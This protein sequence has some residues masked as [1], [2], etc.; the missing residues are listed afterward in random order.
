MAESANRL[1]AEVPESDARLVVLRGAGERAFMSG[2]DIGEQEDEAR[3]ERFLRE[4]GAMIAAIGA[5]PLPV[6]AV[7][8]GYCLGA[9]VAVAAQSDLRIASEDA[10]FGV[11]AARL[12]L[13]YPYP[14]VARLT[15]LVGAGA[16]ADLLLTGRRAGAEEALR[17]GLVQ[18]LHAPT[19]LDRAAAATAAAIAANAPLSLRTAKLAVRTAAA[20]DHDGAARS[21]VDRLYAECGSSRDYA[22][23]RA[24]FRERRPPRFEGR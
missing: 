6:L 16:A 13:A 1:L 23:G 8:R 4:A 14:E 11:P 7:V 10:E 21:E 2:A 18:S 9:G 17:W 19:E 15:E 3:R 20:G 5:L 24:A 22:E 12:G